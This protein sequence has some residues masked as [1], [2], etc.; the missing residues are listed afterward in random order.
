METFTQGARKA[1]ATDALMRDENEVAQRIR[2]DRFKTVVVLLTLGVFAAA[3][4]MLST[5]N[6]VASLG[7]RGGA[8][9]ACLLY[10]SPSP[11]DS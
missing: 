3:F 5:T 8:V 6:V 1:R 10:T 2:K 9:N 7:V 4:L 11:R